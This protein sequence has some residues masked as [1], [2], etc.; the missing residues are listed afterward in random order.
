MRPEAGACLLLLV[1]PGV[2]WASN[3]GC[4]AEWLDVAVIVLAAPVSLALCI[5]AWR[6]TWE[7]TLYWTLGL[8]L[9]TAATVLATPCSYGDDPDGKALLAV[10]IAC[11]PPLALGGRRGR[12]AGE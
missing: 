7:T 8:A 3:F 10:A 1:V 4:A 6:A 9:L 2:A 11:P 12:R 5:V